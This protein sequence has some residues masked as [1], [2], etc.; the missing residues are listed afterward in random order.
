MPDLSK[1]AVQPVDVISGEG[2]SLSE[3]TVS[4]RNGHR[5][6]DR[7]NLVL[8]KNSITCIIGPSGCGKSTLLRAVAGLVQPESGEIRLD[9]APV[10]P[11]DTRIGF[12]PQNFG[13]LPWKTVRANIAMAM[14]LAEKGAQ[15]KSAAER[16][17]EIARWLAAMGIAGLKDRYPLSLSGGQQQRV[18][19][20]R[21]FALHPALLLLDE[22]FSALDAMT[23]ESMQQLLWT[24]WREHPATALFV[25]H[26]VEEAVLLGERILVMPKSREAGTVLMDNP[27]SHLDW[28]GRRESACFFEQTNLVRKVIRDKW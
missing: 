11:K 19:I 5:P 26:D 7:F 17:A 22:P 28:E 15:P 16:E 12:V 23:R 3:I 4:Y 27:A 18:A 24:S 13:L 20:A 25:T 6:L 21:A 14:K 9:G 2:L 1:G 8:P 10:R